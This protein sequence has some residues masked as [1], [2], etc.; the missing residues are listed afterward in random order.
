MMQSALKETYAQD[1][2]GAPGVYSWKETVNFKTVY[3]QFYSLYASADDDAL[4]A[5]KAE[6]GLF[7]ADGSAMYPDSFSFRVVN[8]YG[9]KKNNGNYDVIRENGK[10][11]NFAVYVRE[12]ASYGS[13]VGNSAS[14]SETQENRT[15]Y[16]KLVATVSAD[17]KQSTLFTLTDPDMNGS[18][19]ISYG[20]S[21]L[22]DIESYYVS[23][24]QAK[25]GLKVTLKELDNLLSRE[26]LDEYISFDFKESKHVSNKT[27]TLVTFKVKDAYFSDFGYSESNPSIFSG[28]EYVSVEL[29]NGKISQIKT[30]IKDIKPFLGIQSLASPS[31]PYTLNITYLGQKVNKP[32]ANLSKSEKNWTETVTDQW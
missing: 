9:E 16:N 14:I 7:K 29:L 21:A 19:P 18:L 15:V 6:T 17:T 10:I 30:Y 8:I 22:D 11:K 24:V 2:D 23:A 31:E 3:D 28:A 5:A 13:R 12:E 25:F 26:T 20:V 32:R 4:A 1:P 27:V